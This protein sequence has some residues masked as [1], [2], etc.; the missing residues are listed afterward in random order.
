MVRA[1]VD[2]YTMSS[3]NMENRVR[4]GITKFLPHDLTEESKELI[5]RLIKYSKM[6]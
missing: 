3:E 6:R 1:K 2:T 5:S 4:Y